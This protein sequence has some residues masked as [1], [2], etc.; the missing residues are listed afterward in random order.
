VE[1]MRPEK[2]YSASQIPPSSG[3]TTKPRQN[4]L[5]VARGNLERGPR[6]S[7]LNLLAKMECRMRIRKKNVY[8]K[9][10]IYLVC[11]INVIDRCCF[12]FY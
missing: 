12:S 7:G 9:K 1:E 4:I 5:E 3:P 8:K 11:S 6:G 2:A 10:Y